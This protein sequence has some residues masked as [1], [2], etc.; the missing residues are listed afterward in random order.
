[1]RRWLENKRRYTQ[2]TTEAA[3][4]DELHPEG[5]AAVPDLEAVAVR[6]V[7]GARPQRGVRAQQQPQDAR[8]D[9]VELEEKKF[10]GNVVIYFSFYFPFF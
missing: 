2:Q 6:A 3:A 5:V 7:V 8:V 4:L 9:E 1:M 10:A